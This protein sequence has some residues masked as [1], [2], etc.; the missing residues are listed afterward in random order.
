MIAMAKSLNLT[1]D[2]LIKYFAS[3]RTQYGKL[4]MK[5]SGQAS[6]SK[7]LTHHQHWVLPKY[8]FLARHIITPVMRPLGN[9][10]FS[11]FINFDVVFNLCAYYL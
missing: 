5:K 4:K 11:I 7:L 1:Y 2:D 3:L 9:V 8:A 6:V 10:C